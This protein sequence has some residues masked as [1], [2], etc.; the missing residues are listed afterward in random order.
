MNYFQYHGS[1]IWD[2]RR[3]ILEQ[4][5]FCDEAS[6]EVFRY[7]KRGNYFVKHEEISSWKFIYKRRLYYFLTDF[8]GQI[9]N[10]FELVISKK[11][12]LSNNTR[13]YYSLEISQR[14]KKLA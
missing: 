10:F 14:Q 4:A 8:S 7:E 2:K 12:C 9:S 11:D 3:E 6:T 1:S 13:N 5:T